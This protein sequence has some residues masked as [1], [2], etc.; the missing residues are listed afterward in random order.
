MRKPT[1]IIRTEI[2]D[3]EKIPIRIKDHGV[4]ISESVRNKIFEPFFTTKPI[5]SGTG[6]GLS[7]SYS[8]V[9]EKHGDQL[10]C[11]ST[12]GVG[13]EFAIALPHHS[14]SRQY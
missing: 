13:T 9:V 11:N 4:G 2:P 3:P 14:R 10:T 1:I 5:G 8:I 7:I 12:L 6:L